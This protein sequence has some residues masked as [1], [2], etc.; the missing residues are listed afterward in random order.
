MAIAV[1]R[2]MTKR[3]RRASQSN[4]EPSTVNNKRLNMQNTA[5]DR[6]S[7]GYELSGSG[8]AFA[9][10]HSKTNNTPLHRNFR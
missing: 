2:Q 1:L 8:R 7:A 9:E 4:A 3:T 10:N 5:A 6:S